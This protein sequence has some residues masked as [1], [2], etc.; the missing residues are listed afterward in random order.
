MGR[1]TINDRGKTERTPLL[2]ITPAEESINDVSTKRKSKPTSI[3]SKLTRSTSFS[4]RSDDDDAISP[5]T[6]TSEE[7]QHNDLFYS[8]MKYY[9]KLS[10]NQMEDPNQKGA[11]NLHQPPEHVLPVDIFIVPWRT[12]KGSSSS[13]FSVIF[14]I[15]NTM[16]GS[17]MLSL[18]W[19]IREAGVI[20]GIII[21]CF[22]ATI[23][24]YTCTLVVQNTTM[25][26]LS[27][28]GDICVKSLGQWSRILA[29]IA[30]S[31][32]LVAAACVYHVVMKDCLTSIVTGFI[33]IPLNQEPPEY[34]NVIMALF[35]I[36][37]IFPFTTFKTLNILVKLTSL[38]VIFVL[39]INVFILG[40]CIVEFIVPGYFEEDRVEPV[41]MKPILQV[42]F[43]T[44]GAKL[45][46]IFS[47]SFFI[48]NVISSI[49]N[50]YPEEKK[51][52]KK[53]ILR[54]VFAAYFLASL[55]Y[56][57]PSITASLAFRTG[58][59]QDNFLNQFPPGNIMANIARG[60]VF[61][62]LISIYPLLI[63]IV[64][65]QFFGTLWGVSYPGTT[66]VWMLALCCCTVTTLIAIFYPNIG[67]IIQYAGAVCGAVYLYFLPIAVH[68]VRQ[69]QKK[70]L[71]IFGLIFNVAIFLLG[72]ITISVQFVPVSITDALFKKIGVHV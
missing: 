30:S 6:T 29:L 21:L 54:D 50:K 5:I 38:G 31:I 68:L 14:S 66:A 20:P 1:S 60:F 67:T 34:L 8:R 4:S 23:S 64:R 2:R 57:A 52:S 59:I 24:F 49:L 44:H 3:L 71:T 61:F 25:E 55:C 19:A 70:K 15:W 63:F 51:T 10:M 9:N 39:G 58:P 18:P 72:I 47:L 65:V 43:S 53:H 32:I 36:A 33:Y 41:V 48:H 69:K 40:T 7:A 45:F 35:V 27:D 16:V 22:M 62:Q 26:K 42:L 37:L 13:S 12:E 56:A 46:G 28:F 17:T 11:L